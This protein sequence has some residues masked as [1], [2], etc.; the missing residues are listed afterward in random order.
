MKKISV[1][2]RKSGLFFFVIRF[3]SALKIA[4]VRMV[5]GKH[6]ASGSVLAYTGNP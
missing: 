4:E 6:F 5:M 1:I 2:I 3:L